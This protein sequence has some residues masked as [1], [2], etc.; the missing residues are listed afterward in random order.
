MASLAD[1]KR[2]T[3]QLLNS[4]KG[5]KNFVLSSGCDTPPGIPHENIHAFYEALHEFNNHPVV[6]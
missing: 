2:L 1:M 3:M 4:V 6:L 5:H